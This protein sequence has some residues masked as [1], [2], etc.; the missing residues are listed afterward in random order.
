MYVKT[1]VLDFD[2]YL[3]ITAFFISHV[4]YMLP[5]NFLCLLLA[6]TS[7]AMDVFGGFI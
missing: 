2:I 6:L 1:H 7:V 5:S 3:P 4:I